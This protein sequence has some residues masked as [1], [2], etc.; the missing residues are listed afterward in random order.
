M[1]RSFNARQGTRNHKG[2]LII[3]RKGQ[4]SVVHKT[5]SK[6]QEFSQNQSR[7]GIR[8]GETDSVGEKFTQG[9]MC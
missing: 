4:F 6:H 7:H 8:N 3:L 1:V 9:K 5:A 2:G